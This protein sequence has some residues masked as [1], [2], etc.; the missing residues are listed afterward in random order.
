MKVV[1]AIY[2]FIVGD[3]IIL[4][5]VIVAIV[6]LALINTVSILAPLQGATGYL[7][8]AAVIGVLTATLYREARGKR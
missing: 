6:I 5:G 1:K 4:V 7:L 3:M 8:I 2:D